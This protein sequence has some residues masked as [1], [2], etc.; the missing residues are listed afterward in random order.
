MERLEGP[1][2]LSSAAEK[3]RERL[4]SSRIDEEGDF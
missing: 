2:R 4:A 1:R 3:N